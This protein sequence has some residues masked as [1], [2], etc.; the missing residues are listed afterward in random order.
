MPYID[1]VLRD[2]TAWRTG[3]Q[4]QNAQTIKVFHEAAHYSPALPEVL[5]ANTIKF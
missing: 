5:T 1:Q 4:L 2:N 3:G